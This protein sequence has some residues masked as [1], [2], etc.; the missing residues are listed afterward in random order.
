MH[1]KS[2]EDKPV[3]GVLLGEAAGIGPE[4]VAKAASAGI[5]NA[6]C[7]PV[8]IGDVRVL[9]QGMEIAKVDFPYT[10]IEDI[11]NADWNMGIPVLDQKNLNPEEIKLGELNP[12]SG[13]VTGD[14][15]DTSVNLFKQGKIEGICFAPFNKAAMKLGGHN[16]ESEHAHFAELFNWTEPS[17]E[18]NMLGNLFTTRVTSHVPIKEVSNNLTIENV[19]SAIKLAYSTSRRTGMKN[20]RVAIA[21]LNPHGGESGLCGREEIDVIAPAIEEAKKLGMSISGPYP[22]DVL[23]IKAFN[24]DFDVAVTMYHDQG[25]IAMKLKG[26]EYA[27]TIAAGFPAPI[28]TPAHGTAFDI[29]GKGI[30][31][32]TAFEN[33]LKA[34]CSMARNEMISI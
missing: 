13:K 3:I 32:I 33:A 10:V 7:Y 11:D 27:V 22:G 19:L 14:Q 6:N 30:C 25:Q 34:A 26:F 16:Y 2:C 1:C 24:G 18:V 15:I 29:A 23:F 28:T 9:K 8:I 21:A 5:L 20:P 4:I 31:K 12:K 17:G